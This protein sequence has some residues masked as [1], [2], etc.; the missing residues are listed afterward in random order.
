MPAK[1]NGE[2]AEFSPVPVPP[3]FPP[4]LLAVAPEAAAALPE[5]LPVSELADP[6]PPA[7][8]GADELL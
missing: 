6:D 8:A 7:V 5:L 4:I 2:L 3:E 1:F